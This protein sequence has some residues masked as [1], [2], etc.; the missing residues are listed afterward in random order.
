MPCRQVST[1]NGTAASSGSYRTEAEC[2]QACREGA[3]CE[4]TTCSVKPACQCQCTSGSCCGPDTFTNATNET[5]PRCRD[6]SQA[7]CLARGGVWRCG[8]PCRQLASDP[9]AG[10]GLGSGICGSLD[11]PASI[12]PVFKGVGTTCSPNPCGCCGNGET[13]PAGAVTVTVNRT[14]DVLANSGCGCGPGGSS[15]SVA[16]RCRDES[17]VF[18]QYGVPGPCTLPVSGQTPQLEKY[19]TVGITSACLL[20]TAIDWAL[21]PCGF[22]PSGALS[23]TVYYAWPFVQSQTTYSA[24]YYSFL[25]VDGAGTSTAVLST[26]ST[27]PNAPPHPFPSSGRSFFY[28]GAMWSV[29][30]TVNFA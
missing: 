10:L 1:F 30:I 25:F 16:T 28:A 21:T 5:G 13:F 29:S 4:G 11:P 8:V 6:E 14:L 24:A 22:G 7:D 26:S 20:Y 2:N 17:A 19:G 3:C 18:S 9:A 15:P 23:Q 12:A 27:V